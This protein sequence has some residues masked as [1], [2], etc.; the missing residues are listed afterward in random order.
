MIKHGNNIAGVM[1]GSGWWNPLPLKLFGRFEIRKY[2][3]T[4]RPCVKAE[5]HVRYADGSEETI[6]TDDTWLAAPGP[7]IKNSVYL[8]EHYDA[9]LEQNW[10]TSAVDK[11]EWKKA[12]V[13]D[14]PTG[15]LSAQMLPPIRVTKTLKPVKIS[16]AKPDTFIVDMG[17]NFAG[18]ARI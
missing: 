1:S 4:D 2:Q 3:Q 18:V 9:R 5:I 10:S 14:G 8:G 12:I 13:V 15:E 11:K 16:E 17:Q 7:I 6:V